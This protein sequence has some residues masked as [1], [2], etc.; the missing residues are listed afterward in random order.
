MPS[1]L[2]VLA[3]IG[4]IIIFVFFGEKVVRSLVRNVVG[5]VHAAKDEYEITKKKFETKDTPETI[6]S[7]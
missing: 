1:E 6:I 7:K 3:I 2:T 5:G 4:A